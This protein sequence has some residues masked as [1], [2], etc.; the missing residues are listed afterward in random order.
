MNYEACLDAM[1]E[2]LRQGAESSAIDWLYQ[3]IR[4]QDAEDLVLGKLHETPGT[5]FLVL[6]EPR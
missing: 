3:A 4:C 1:R 2:A 5:W 6:R